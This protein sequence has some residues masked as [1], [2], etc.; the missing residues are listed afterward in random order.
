MYLDI[1]INL[2]TDLLGMK[3]NGRNVLINGTSHTLETR[4]LLPIVF[5]FF[6]LFSF[7]AS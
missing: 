7:S 3:V 5:V 1:Y 4:S 2:K 6:F